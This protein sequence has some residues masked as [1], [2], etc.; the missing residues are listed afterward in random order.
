[1]EV[2][3]DGYGVTR[4]VDLCMMHGHMTYTTTLLRGV[5]QPSSLRKTARDYCRKPTTVQLNEGEWGGPVVKALVH[6]TDITGSIP[7]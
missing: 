3:P 5:A 2:Q 1:M 7:T 6:H 4:L